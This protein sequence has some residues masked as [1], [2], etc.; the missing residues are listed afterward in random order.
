MYKKKVVKNESFNTKDDSKVKLVG[1]GIQEKNLNES[2]IQ[3]TI[4]VTD[5]AKN[6]IRNAN[7][8]IQIPE[9]ITI[10]SIKSDESH[11][12]LKIWMEKVKM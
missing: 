7:S 10:I 6:L 11:D 12:V 1:G 3:V 9:R 2:V 5:K 8:N 4:P